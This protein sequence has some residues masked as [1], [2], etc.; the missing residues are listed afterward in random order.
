MVHCGRG[1]GA[2]MPLIPFSSG[3]TATSRRARCRRWRSH[4]CHG[5]EAITDGPRRRRGYERSGGPER[6][7][8]HLNGGPGQRTRRSVPSHPDTSSAWKPP[9]ASRRSPPGKSMCPW[10][11][12][13]TRCPSSASWLKG[14]SDAASDQARLAALAPGQRIRVPTMHATFLHS[15]HKSFNHECLHSASVPRLLSRLLICRPPKLLHNR[16]TGAAG[17]ALFGRCSF[18]GKPKRVHRVKRLIKV[19]VPPSFSW[20]ISPKLLH[21][22][23]FYSKRVNVSIDSSEDQTHLTRIGSTDPRASF[24]ARPARPPSAR[25]Y[26]RVGVLLTA[27]CR[28]ASP[29]VRADAYAQP[30]RVPGAF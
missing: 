8:C 24:S 27:V 2:D 9:Q 1:P 23:P 20:R 4:C 14:R 19:N 25:P 6:C 30:A 10:I 7:E 13:R 26:R 29:K 12:I 5:H 18:W 11:C 15:D 16:P 17:P 21:L 28:P 22:G 3:A